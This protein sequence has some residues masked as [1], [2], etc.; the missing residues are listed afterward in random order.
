MSSIKPDGLPSAY[1]LHDIESRANAH[2]TPNGMHVVWDD[3]QNAR[4]EGM[5]PCPW[6]G[7]FHDLHRQPFIQARD[8]AVGYAEARVICPCC[9]VS[10]TYVDVTRTTRTDT[11]EDVTRD[12]AIEKAVHLW[13]DG[14]RRNRSTDA[15]G[16]D[17]RI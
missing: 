12:L 16:T 11:G 9:H 14:L 2:D 5:E 8:S 7:P 17:K 6:C 15:H 1:E 10:T 4:V 3:G 13:N